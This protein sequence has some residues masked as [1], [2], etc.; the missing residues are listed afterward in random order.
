MIGS[1]AGIPSK[2]DPGKVVESSLFEG[3]AISEVVTSESKVVSKRLFVRTGGLG[4]ENEV[5]MTGTNQPDKWINHNDGFTN[6]LF[7]TIQN[8]RSFLIKCNSLS[9]W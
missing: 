7:E 8:L 4:L 9:S 6:H 5:I 2:S 3:E 1:I